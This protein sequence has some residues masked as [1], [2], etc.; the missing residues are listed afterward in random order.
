MFLTIINKNTIESIPLDTVI[1]FVYFSSPEKYL[2]TLAEIE[3]TMDLLMG[4]VT[5]SK[6]IEIS[7]KV[8]L[9]G[10]EMIKKFL[11]TN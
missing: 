6:K 9:E 8:N 2:L 11:E 10:F 4:R 3:S 5:K 1:S 7:K